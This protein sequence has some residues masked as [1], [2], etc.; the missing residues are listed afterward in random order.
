M[1]LDLFFQILEYVAVAV[2]FIYVIFQILQKPLMWYLCILAAILSMVVFLYRGLYA[3]TAVQVYLII[4]GIYGLLDWKKA[5]SDNAASGNADKIIV[6][7]FEWKVGIVS[8]AL[9]VAIF[10]LLKYLLAK[11]AS[12]DA[13]AWLPVADALLATNTILATFFTGR[14]YIISWVM[15][16]VFDAVAVLIYFQMKMYPYALLFAC[17]VVMAAIGFFNWKKNGVWEKNN[18]VI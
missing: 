2:A 4:A 16:F 9:S 10:F 14:R 7:P 17:Y 1:T 3:M 13:P 8:V 5:K 6:R 12:A 15:W 11:V 18:S